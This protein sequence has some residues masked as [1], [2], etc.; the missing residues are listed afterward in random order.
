MN[1]KEPGFVSMPGHLIRRCHQ[2]AVALLLEE[3]SR[4]N[5]TPVQ[6]GILSALEAYPEIEQNQLPGI[7]AV[8]RSTI[9]SVAFRLEERGLIQRRGDKIDRRRKKLS[10]T[11]AGE[12]FLEEVTEKV[13]KAQRS[14]LAPLDEEERVEF[15]RLMSKMSDMNNFASRAPLKETRSQTKANS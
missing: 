14:I 10:L 8:D 9:G 5:I 3:C 7:I 12:E 11:R 13:E 6:Y 15:I 4:F 1:E 2:I